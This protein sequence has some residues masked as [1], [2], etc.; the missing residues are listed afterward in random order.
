MVDFKAIHKTIKDHITGK[1]FKY[2]TAAKWFNFELGSFPASSH[3]NAFAVH[4]G[5]GKRTQEYEA[6]DWCD[7]PWT[8]E[9]CLEGMR[10]HYLKK[11]GA[12]YDAIR[13]LEGIT[14]DHIAEIEFLDWNWQNFEEHAILTFE[15]KV[16]INE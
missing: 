6:Y 10:D 2:L 11:M 5:S 4:P 13:S 3:N 14:A 15:I 7:S 16:T 1:G 9:F 8:V 12:A